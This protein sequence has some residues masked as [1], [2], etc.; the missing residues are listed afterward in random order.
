MRALGQNRTMV[1]VLVEQVAVQG[2]FYAVF[3]GLPM[4]LERVRLFPPATTGLLMQPIAA[5]GVVA[6]PVAARLAGSV[7]AWLPLL[8]GSV[9]LV[10][11]CGALLLV[12]GTTSVIGIVAVTAVLGL[13]NGFNNMGL[14]S[15]LYRSA[16]ADNAGVAAGLFQTGRYIGA[17]SSA[18]L[19]GIVFARDVSTAT[20][21]HVAAITGVVAVLLL[22]AAGLGVRGSRRSCAL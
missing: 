4:W 18:A 10:A 20:L 16:S 9:G 19:L 17:I 11:G 2:V 5:L 21:H 6:T 7:G 12:N 13:P 3:F 14:Q 8:I 1:A 22:V 15:A